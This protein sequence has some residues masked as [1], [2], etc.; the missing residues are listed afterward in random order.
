MPQIKE[1]VSNKFDGNES[2]IQVII[3]V[4]K[5]WILTFSTYLNFDEFLVVGYFKNQISK[6]PKQSK[7]MPHVSSH[8]TLSIPRNKQITTKKQTV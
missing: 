5:S 1:P 8:R 2:K 6:R 7:K 3:F 4:P